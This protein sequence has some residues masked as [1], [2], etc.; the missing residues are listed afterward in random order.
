MIQT[1]ACTSVSVSRDGRALEPSVGETLQGDR[2]RR[3]ER[4]DGVLG[5]GREDA[6]EV[7]LDPE[8]E[9][10]SARLAVAADL[11]VDVDQSACVDDEV[12]CVED[13]ALVELVG[14]SL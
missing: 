5:R 7:R 6:V 12:R 11:P 8:R 10:T 9:L 3:L 1:S 2:L 4:R 14:Q 13:A